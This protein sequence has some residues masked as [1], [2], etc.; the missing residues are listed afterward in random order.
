[1][2]YRFG[3]CYAASKFAL[4][5]R[6]MD[7]LIGMGTGE[8]V[9]FLLQHAVRMTDQLGA[10]GGRRPSIIVMVHWYR[11]VL[12]RLTTSTHQLTLHTDAEFPQGPL[13]SGRP[14]FRGQ[15]SFNC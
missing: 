4:S 6:G 9:Y 5:F 11:S 15:S 10:L 1:M 3:V 13:E 8:C 7:G 12:V 2:W 14:S